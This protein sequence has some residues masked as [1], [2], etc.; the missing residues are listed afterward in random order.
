MYAYKCKNNGGYIAEGFD[1]R[2]W[3]A[4]A[5][6]VE[7]FAN[8][9]H[10]PINWLWHISG[11]GRSTYPNPYKTILEVI[12]SEFVCTLTL[13]RDY[14]LFYNTLYDAYW[15][16]FCGQFFDTLIELQIWC[17]E[18]DAQTYPC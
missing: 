8:T 7:S 1:F 11:V 14:P 9:M 10:L 4:T 12:M 17:N 2:Y 16:P 5:V 3:F 13:S 15:T 6:E 18:V